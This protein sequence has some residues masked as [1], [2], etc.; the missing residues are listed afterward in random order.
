MFKLQGS[1]LIEEYAV[2]QK[3]C[4]KELF[5]TTGFSEAVANIYSKTNLSI[6][7]T[8]PDLIDQ[9]QICY[10][11]MSMLTVREGIGT[12]VYRRAIDLL[13]DERRAANSLFHQDKFLCPRILY[14]IDVIQHRFF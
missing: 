9:I 13:T 7:N 14:M 12:E 6:A 8:I 1:E 10:R 2:A 4:L 5:R 11:T 3:Q